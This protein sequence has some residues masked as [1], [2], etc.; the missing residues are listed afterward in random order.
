MS[1]NFST[2]VALTP[3]ANTI[4]VVVTDVAGNSTS[5]SRHVFSNVVPPALTLQSPI[6]GLVTN[7]ASV[8]VRGLATPGDP[9]DVVTVTVQGETVAVLPDGSFS[10][11]VALVDGANTIIVVATD[12][13]GLR[14][15]AARSVIRD[16]TPPAITISGVADGQYSN[17]AALA[18]A[19]SATDENLTT[20]TA[21]IDGAP[22]VSGAPV[23]TE[24]A[25]SLVVIAADALPPAV[26]A[27]GARGWAPTVEMTT[28]L[29]GRPV[30]GWLRVAVRTNLLAG[31]WFDEE[32]MVWDA[33]GRLVAQSR[34]LAL[35]GR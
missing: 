26:F 4:A 8:E 28:Y 9:A 7:A 25:H 29:R 22:F 23:S 18:P 2:S 30:A 32:A 31:G 12:G 11:A 14:A 10:A 3:G 13:Y 15:T 5:L 16:A 34:Q 21:T 19:Y 20:V 17:A 35:I 6:N 24:G 33:A 27:L 1:G